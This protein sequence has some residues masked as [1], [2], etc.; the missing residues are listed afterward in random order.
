MVARHR[1]PSRRV[2]RRIALLTA[3]GLAALTLSS[4]LRGPPALVW[5]ATPSVPLGLYGIVRGSPQR[6]DL[7]LIDPPPTVRALT[8]ARGYLSPRALLIKPVIAIAGDRVCRLHSFVW[9]AGHR[10]VI[11][12]PADAQ[13]RLLPSWR[14][15]RVLKPGQ[16]F[17]LG[18]SMDSFDSR[19]FGPIDRLFVVGVAF[20]IWR[21]SDH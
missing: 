20:P 12:R 9:I 15:C 3:F 19:Y 5:N 21:L 6:G 18:R 1:P 14:G 7:V 13:G 11:A 10:V 8:T 17:V 4:F 16:I 2:R